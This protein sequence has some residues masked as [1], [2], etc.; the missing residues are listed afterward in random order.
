MMTFIAIGIEK[1]QPQQVAVASPRLQRIGLIFDRN[2][3]FSVKSNTF[4]S[5]V[6][7]SL[8]IGSREPVTD[9]TLG[10]IKG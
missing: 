3:P 8:P 5:G 6:A 9:Q 4:I 1:R 7:V 10:A 2:N